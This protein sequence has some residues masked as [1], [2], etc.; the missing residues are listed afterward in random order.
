MLEVATTLPEMPKALASMKEH[1]N[2]DRKHVAEWEKLLERI[3]TWRDLPARDIEAALK[4]IMPDWHV[5]TLK[6]AERGLKDSI[7]RFK[8]NADKTER[9]LQD[10]RNALV[11]FLVSARKLESVWGLVQFPEEL[12]FLFKAMEIP[13]LPHTD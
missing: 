9:I 2:M 6:D 1:M 8:E 11:E 13:E 10:C 4:E 3:K 5:T 7:P 12:E